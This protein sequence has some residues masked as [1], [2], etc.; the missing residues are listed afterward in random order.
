MRK[1]YPANTISFAFLTRSYSGTTQSRIPAATVESRA[2][3]STTWVAA[4][5]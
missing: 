3:G 1:L 2:G 4:S 5:G